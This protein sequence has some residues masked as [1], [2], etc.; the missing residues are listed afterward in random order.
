LAPDIEGSTKQEREA[1]VRELFTC[2]GDCDNCGL[3]AIFKGKE[4]E[5]AYADYIEGIRSFR[6]ISEQYR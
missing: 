6:E 4:P 1:Y 2:R 5:I 3:C